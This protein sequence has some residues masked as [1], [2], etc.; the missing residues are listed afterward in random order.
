VVVT[1]IV[2][3]VSQGETHR[4]EREDPIP[5]IGEWYWVRDDEND[6][7]P[8][9]ACVTHVGTNYVE[10]TYGAGDSSWR[11]HFD[12][13]DKRLTLEPDAL[14]LIQSNVIRHQLSAAQYMKEVQEIT[15]RLALTA[16]KRALPG[17]E[18]QAL[19]LRGS[20]ENVEE[21]K[22]ALMKAKDKDL[23]ELFKKIEEENRQAGRWM[24]ATLLPLKAKAAE[25]SPVIKT[26]ESRIFNVELYAGLV[27]QVEQVKD[28]EP[29]PM[30]E[31][32]RLFQRRAY[33]DEECLANYSTGGMEFR[34]LPSFDKWV[35]KKENLDRLLPFQRCMLAFQV[36]RNEKE[37]EITSLR[38]FINIILGG[39]RDADKLTF[40]YIRNGE[41]VFRLN[42]AISFGEQLFPDIEH[43]HL[44]GKLYADV[45]GSGHVKKIVTES[46]YFDMVRED[47]KKRDAFLNK[48][49]EDAHAW[50]PDYE[51]ERFRPYTPDNV[52]YDDITEHL[53]D[54]MERHN[55]LVLVLQG[56]LDRSPVLHPHPPWQ[57]WT[58]EGFTSALELIYDDSRALTPGEK[59]D[60]EAYRAKLNQ[61]LKTGSITV[62]QEDFWERHEAVKLNATVGWRHRE[63]MSSHHRPYGNPGPGTIAKVASFSQTKGCT[64]RW[65]RKRQRVKRWEGQSYDDELPCS[66][67]VPTNKLLNVGAYKPGDYKIFFAD[68]RTRADYLK[69]APL[70][71]EAEEY[72]AGN[73]K[74]GESNR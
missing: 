66:I 31:K 73:R 35:V 14:N 17:S 50:G 16:G 8:L 26:I 13:I 62:G 4:E 3:S 5:Q 51:A 36:R 32:I 29:A 7:K 39:V 6:D 37:R 27:E 63:F 12:N 38:D 19:A 10:V 60:F 45:W 42:T 22:T 72:H 52:Y 47:Q 49:K 61:S 57:L 11:V 74:P 25:L 65:M 70:L 1:E 34:D 9:L 53:H 21:Y 44:T 41:R 46:T 71:L 23:P 56:L 58:P 30:M 20:G 28:G 55:R 54:E 33:M 15:A 2:K 18:T 24:K 68:P 59:P 48:R 40:L 69:W 64:Y 67:T 43:V